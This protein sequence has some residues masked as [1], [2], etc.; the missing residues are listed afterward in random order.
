[1]DDS[2]YI[3]SLQILTGWLLHYK[4]ELIWYFV[5]RLQ[6]GVE[7][8]E[9]KPEADAFFSCNWHWLIFCL[10]PLE[11]S[12]LMF[13]SSRFWCPIDLSLSSLSLQ[14]I[15]LVHRLRDGTK[16]SF[17]SKKRF[18]ERNFTL[19]QGMRANSINNVTSSLHI[20]LQSGSN[21]SGAP[22]SRAYLCFL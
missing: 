17:I 5:C 3:A 13:F 20:L 1:M 7:E 14:G 8:E 6:T 15:L 19:L 4:N 2:I 12:P 22:F 11:S 18:L 21:Q 10:M 9:P 16:F